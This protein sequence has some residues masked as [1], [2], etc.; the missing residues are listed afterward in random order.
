MREFRTYVNATAQTAMNAANESHRPG[1]DL[2]PDSSIKY[3]QTKGVNPPNK[4]VAILYARE[5]LV[6]RTSGGM[7]S[8]R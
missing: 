1:A 4:A 2:L 5:K 6:A 8:V 7:I 3:V